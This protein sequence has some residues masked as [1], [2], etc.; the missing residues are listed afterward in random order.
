[1]RSRVL[2]IK[3]IKSA[4]EANAFL[5]GLVFNQNQKAER[6]WN[7]PYLLKERLGTLNPEE[8]LSIM[9]QTLL[10]KA[11]EERPA[12]HPFVSRT[13]QHIY[14]TCQLLVAEYGGDAR[15]VWRGNKTT[16]EI[17]RELQRFSGI[18]KHKAVALTQGAGE[19][20]SSRLF[21]YTQ[22]SSWTHIKQTA[23]NIA[24]LIS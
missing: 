14:G 1:M 15:N 3:P 9:P 10:Q 17:V 16:S 11:F 6:A 21:I 13:A 4:E 19:A 8:I 22:K 7:A 2:N 5:F 20:Q 24:I 12:L 23:L 18:G